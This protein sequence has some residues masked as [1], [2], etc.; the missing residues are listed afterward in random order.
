M[1][2]VACDSRSRNSKV[3]LGSSTVSTL[4][5]RPSSLPSPRQIELLEVDVS[6]WEKGFF[7][8]CPA[9][10]VCDQLWRVVYDITE[11]QERKVRERNRRLTK[12][13][14]GGRGQKQPISVLNQILGSVSIF[15]LR[16]LKKKKIVVEQISFYIP[17]NSDLLIPQQPDTPEVLCC[18]AFSQQH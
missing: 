16:V 9:T 15:N 13:Q 18:V 17:A 3:N 7:I 6:R 2:V 10:R 14:D 5:P 4:C 12:R 11:E 8:F 1:E